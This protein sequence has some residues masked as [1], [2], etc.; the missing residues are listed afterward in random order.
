MSAPAAFNCGLGPALA[1]I[2]GKWKP[3]IIW[4][5]HAG[6]ERFGSLRRKVSGISEKVLAEQLR[7]LERAGVVR[8]HDFGEKPFKVEYSLTPAGSELNSAV[9]ALAEWGERHASEPSST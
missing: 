4:E 5:L 2:A 1:V 7:D 9:H 3:T 6:P 8:R